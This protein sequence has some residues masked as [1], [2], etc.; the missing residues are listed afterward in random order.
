MTHGRVLDTIEQLEPRQTPEAAPE[1]AREPR[2]EQQEHNGHA[3]RRCHGDERAE[4][5][6]RRLT[7]DWVSQPVFSVGVTEFG[8]YVSGSVA[9]YFSD[10]T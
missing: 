8:T 5:Y 3:Q 10:M 1:H 4:A 2:G 7:L 6:G 9:A